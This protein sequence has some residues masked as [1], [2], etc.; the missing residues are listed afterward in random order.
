MERHE[1]IV[2]CS[3]CKGKGCERCRFTGQR[4]VSVY[5]PTDDKEKKDGDRRE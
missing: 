2:T 1:E 5:V 3:D 4:I